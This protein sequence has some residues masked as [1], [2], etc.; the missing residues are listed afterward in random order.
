MGLTGA[1]TP[2]DRAIPRDISIAGMTRPHLTLSLTRRLFNGKNF[3]GTAALAEERAL[4]STIL[5]TLRAMLHS[6]L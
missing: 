5:V 3:A 2:Q 4:L 1:N 6:V